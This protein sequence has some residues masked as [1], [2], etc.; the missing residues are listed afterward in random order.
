[1]SLLGRGTPGITC[2]IHD[3]RSRAWTRLASRSFRTEITWGLWRGEI[4]GWLVRRHRSFGFGLE[5]CAPFLW[6]C[7]PATVLKLPQ[8]DLK[9]KRKRAL[10]GPAAWYNCR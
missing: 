8:S 1:M 3:G 5:P 9:I 6:V 7:E 4:Q 2:S 10:E